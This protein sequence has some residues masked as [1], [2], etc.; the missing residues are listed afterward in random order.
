MAS[1]APAGSRSVTRSARTWFHWMNSSVSYRISASV[2]VLTLA[3]GGA[4]GWGSFVLSRKLVE[5]GISKE[6]LHESTL[7]ASRS[8]HLQRAAPTFPGWRNASSLTACPTGT[9]A[10]SRRSSPITESAHVH[11]AGAVRRGGGSSSVGA[12]PRPRARA[13]PGSSASPSWLYAAIEK[14]RA[15]PNWC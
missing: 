3:I 13:R 7:G 15:A 2:L 5:D 6:V 1:N 8:I 10:T 12:G 14:D 9:C 11:H 4:L